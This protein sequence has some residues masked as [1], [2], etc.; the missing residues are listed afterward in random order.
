LLKI[1]RS[2]AHSHILLSELQAF[3]VSVSESG[4]ARFEAGGGA[5]DDLV[6]AVALA[7]WRLMVLE[8]ATADSRVPPG[9]AR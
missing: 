7:L 9:S 2:L 5:H 1:A 8:G 4:H 3:R 6:L